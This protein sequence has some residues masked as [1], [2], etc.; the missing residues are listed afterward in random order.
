[1]DTSLHGSYENAPQI[2]SVIIV[3]YNTDTKDLDLCLNKLK[4]QNEDNF[5]IILIDNNDQNDITGILSKYKLK[6][7]KLKMNYGVNVGRN[8]GIMHSNG[9]IIIFLD[10]DAIP[11]VNFVQEHI[12]VHKNPHILALRGKVLPKSENVYNFFAY[13]YDLG[14]EV[15][16]WMIDIE[17]NSSFKKEVLLDIGGFNP[18]LWG[19]EGIEISY[20]IIKKY[21]DI[22]QLLYSPDPVIYHDYSHSFKKYIKKQI[23]HDKI[24]E[25]LSFSFPDIFRFCSSYQIQQESNCNRSEHSMITRIKIFTIK[26]ITSI[27]RHIYC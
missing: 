10:D 5:E 18:N 11:D 17:G 19:H 8:I 22:S 14:R 26:K 16:P 4:M 25:K 12:N 3:T 1:M 24:S 13:G 2:A 20:R 6:Y 21:G 15:V 9:N 7:I 23:R 27:V